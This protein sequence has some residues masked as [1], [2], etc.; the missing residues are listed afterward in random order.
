MENDPALA[1][2]LEPARI[3]GRNALFP[4]FNA[5]LHRESVLEEYSD[6]IMQFQTV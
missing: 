4:T 6:N 5:F 2:G 3:S 1:V